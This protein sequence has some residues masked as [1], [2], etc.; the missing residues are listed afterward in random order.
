MTT[1]AKVAANRRNAVRSTGPRTPEG[2]A[3]S[4]RNALRHGLLSREVLLPK[5]R[6]E[7]LAS[8]AE[9]L[10]S[11]LRP[12]GELED[13]L[14]DR[15]LSS[16]WRLRRVLAVEAGL[17]APP[18]PAKSASTLALE[19]M[20]RGYAEDEEPREL[21]TADHFHEDA[22]GADAFPKL[23]RYEAGIE[24]ALFRALHELQRLQASRAG[25]PVPPPVAVDVELALPEN[26]GAEA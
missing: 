21:T 1:P 5:E 14:V 22:F 26:A 24:R 20:A 11:E 15:I 13:L 6:G 12:V 25:A 17:F 16:A 19:R 7:D 18:P 8:F 10:R 23:S 3:S 9:R 4:S 2:K